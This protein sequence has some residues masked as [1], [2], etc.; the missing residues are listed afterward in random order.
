MKKIIS[1]FTVFTLFSFC[2]SGPE[3]SVNIFEAAKTGNVDELNLHIEGGSN[4]NERAELNLS[5]IHI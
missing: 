4:L 5:L 2:S 1:I 3:A